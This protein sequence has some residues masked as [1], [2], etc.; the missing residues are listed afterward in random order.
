MS[1]TESTRRYADHEGRSHSHSQGQGTGKK[2]AVAGLGVALA[3]ILTC[4]LPVMLGA[5]AL[6]GAGSLLAG[7]EA[8]GLIVLASA[9]GLIVLA[10]AGLGLVWWALRHRR[11]AANGTSCSTSCGCGDRHDRQRR[12]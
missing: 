12:Q 8:V 7:A 1:A 2:G 10:S 6:A 5:G 9:G 4:F 11:A 3:C